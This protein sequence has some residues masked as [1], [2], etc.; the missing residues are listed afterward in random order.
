MT[1]IR[2]LLSSEGIKTDPRKI[3]AIVNMETPFDLQG[4]QLP[5]GIAKYFFK[6]LKN[7]SESCQPLCKLTHKW[8]QEQEEAFYSLKV[9]VTQA[10][11][12]NYF[13]PQT[14]AEGQGDAFKNGLGFVL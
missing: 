1:F 12:L 7:L 2:H 9:A 11:I 4:V 5:M 6:F 14:K 3:D 10:P 8:T 13:C